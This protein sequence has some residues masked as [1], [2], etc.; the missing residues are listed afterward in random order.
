VGAPRAQRAARHRA[1]AHRHGARRGRWAHDPLRAP[2]A[3]HDARPREGQA[4]GRALR[5]DHRG[6]RPRLGGHPLPLPRPAHRRRLLLRR[7]PALQHPDRPRDPHGRH[8]A[9][10][11]L[12]APPRAA[13]RAPAQRARQLPESPVPARQ[14]AQR[15]PARPRR[16]RPRR[17]LSPQP[18]DR[19]ARADAAA[20][21]IRARRAGHRGGPRTALPARL[22]ARLPAVGGHRRD[23]GRVPAAG[24]PPLEGASALGPDGA[25][26]R[27]RDRPVRRDRPRLVPSLRRRLRARPHRARPSG[28]AR[29]P[30]RGPGLLRGARRAGIWRGRRTSVTSGQPLGPRVPS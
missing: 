18:F 24:P 11:R 20:R 3:G 6:A 21:G 27:T 7:R 9:G 8:A 1:R 25:P 10:R 26:A 16:L 22:D 4:P 29:P 5:A 28:R 14:G 15:A 2:R 19:D 17:A 12:V 23:G 13:R 30:R